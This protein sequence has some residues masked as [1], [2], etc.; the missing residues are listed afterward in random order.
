MAEAFFLV[1]VILYALVTIKVDQWF[2]ISRLGFKTETPVR[3]FMYPSGFQSLRIVL[4]IF[5]VMPIIDL[6]VI[7]WYVGVLILAVVSLAAILIGHKLAFNDYR[8]IH[9]ELIAHE[10]NLK[11]SDPSEYARFLGDE[12]PTAHR[13]ELEQGAR[14]TARE[15]MKLVKISIELEKHT[16]R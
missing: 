12:D 5:T 14:R 11:V 2:T 15:L 3:F 1:L 9:R 10:E 6:K 4:F 8:R 13:V 7:P 16:P